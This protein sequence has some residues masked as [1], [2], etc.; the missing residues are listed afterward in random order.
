MILRPRKDWTPTAPGGDP[1]RVKRGAFTLFVHYSEGDGRRLDTLDEQRAAIRAIRAFHVGPQ[2]QWAD[3]A[4][5]FVLAQPWGAKGAPR[6]WVARGASKVPASQQGHN[7]GNLSVCVLADA[8]DYI[9]E[10]TATGIAWL[11]RRTGAARIL[12]HRD[13]NSTDC[14]GDRLYAELPS[15]R[16]M[17]GL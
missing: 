17:A 16:R 10:R 1:Q 7:A 11:A 12:G 4:Y 2:R 9:M 13:V 14:P 5:S 8:N 3:I 15:I 6:L